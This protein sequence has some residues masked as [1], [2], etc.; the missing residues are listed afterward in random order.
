MTA[1]PICNV[2]GIRSPCAG[3]Y[4]ALSDVEDVPPPHAKGF[5][6]FDE[7]YLDQ[8]PLYFFAETGGPNGLCSQE[9]NGGG[10]DKF[11]AGLIG[12]AQLSQ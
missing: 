11:S 3:A 2:Q 6:S 7:S 12:T 4:Y 10:C 9:G 5:E 1:V 8:A